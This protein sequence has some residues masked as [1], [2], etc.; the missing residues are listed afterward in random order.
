MIQIPEIVDIVFHESLLKIVA[1]FL[2][3]I[4]QYY[5]GVVGRDFP[6]DEPRESSFFHK[7]SDDRKWVNIF[8]FL[9][10][11][12][13]TTGYQEY[14][15]GSHRYDSKS[16]RPRLTRDLGIEGAGGHYL[17]DEIKFHYRLGIF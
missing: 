12:T 13:D 5:H 8:V 6:S 15:P 3:Y 2:S 14:V 16:C 10:D 4:P 17:D 11:S 7:D 9:E 1:N